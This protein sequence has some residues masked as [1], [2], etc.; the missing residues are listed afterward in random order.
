MAPKA[1]YEIGCGTGMLLMQIAPICDLYVAIDFAPAVLAGLNAQL[2]KVPTLTERVRVMERTADNFEGLYQNSF[3]CVVIN[4]AAQY[5]PNVT[6]LTRVLEGAVNIVKPGGHIFVGDVRSL[7]LLPTFASSVELFQA[8]DEISVGQ[9]RER[10]QRRLRSEQQLVL[11][12]AYFRF[13]QRRF[14]KIS[15]VEIQLRRGRADNEMT[16]YRYNAILHVGQGTE[17]A[18]NVAF[19]AWAEGELAPDE[20]HSELLRRPNQPIGFKCIRNARIEKDLAVLK[21]L[22]DA[23]ATRT[24][25]EL[26]REGEQD[27]IPGIHPQDLLDL[28]TDDSSFRVFLSWAACRPDGSYDALF[29]PR[30][31]L[32]ENRPSAIPWPEPEASEFVHLRTPPDKVNFDVS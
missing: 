20:I 24:A 13:L 27:V 21:I 16:R 6:Y 17:A 11:S 14:P 30:G 18:N 12:P 1:L 15:S 23:D 22:R 31:S 10:I 8:T 5:F 32:Q 4:S 9:L 3:D 28:E 29:I 25:L 26:R 2:G 19:E 7:P